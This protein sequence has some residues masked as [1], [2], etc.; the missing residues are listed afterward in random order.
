MWN[1]H[2]LAN[3]QL[4]EVDRRSPCDVALVR[5][6]ITSALIPVVTVTQADLPG[7]LKDGEI[8]LATYAI[9]VGVIL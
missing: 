6:V 8:V 9:L 1:M 7:P 4:S 3:P 2:C 5:R